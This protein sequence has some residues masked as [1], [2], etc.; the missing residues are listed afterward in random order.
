[1]GPAGLG[2]KVGVIIPSGQWDTALQCIIK[3][4]RPAEILLVTSLD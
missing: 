3:T 4:V 2:R 1:M